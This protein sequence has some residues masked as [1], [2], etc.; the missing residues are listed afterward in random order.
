[1]KKI[2]KAK[3]KRNEICINNQSKMKEENNENNVIEMK[4][5]VMK[6]WSNR[7]IKEIKEIIMKKKISIM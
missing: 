2:M 4:M 1:M 7:R 5:K 3:M 6:K